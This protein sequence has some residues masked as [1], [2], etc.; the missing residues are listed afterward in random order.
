MPALDLFRCAIP[1]DRPPSGGTHTSP[2]LSGYGPLAWAVPEELAHGAAAAEVLLTGWERREDTRF[3]V[4]AR[5]PRGHSF[6]TPVNGTHCGPLRAEET[7]RQAGSLPAPA[8]SAVPLGHQ[9]LTHDLE[10]AAHPQHLGLTC[11]GPE[12]YRSVRGS[13]L[14]GKPRSGATV[15]ARSAPM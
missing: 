5:W 15:T 6:F 7:I 12:V 11:A 4:E 8:E 9:F 10:V 2:F 3:T 14:P 1:A 13:R